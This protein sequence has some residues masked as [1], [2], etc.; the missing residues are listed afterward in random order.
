MEQ[1]EEKSF[2]EYERNTQSIKQEIISSDEFSYLPISVQK[3][4]NN[5]YYHLYDFKDEFIKSRSN[6]TNLMKN[7][8]I[9]VN[10]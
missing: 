8:N 1:Q 6:A 5:E 7:K 10:W 4:I 9:L 2:N 3:K